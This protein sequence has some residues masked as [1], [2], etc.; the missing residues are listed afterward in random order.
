MDPR[1]LPELAAA[2]RPGDP[3]LTT[4]IA[5][6]VR[7]LRAANDPVDRTALYSLGHWLKARGIDA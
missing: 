2:R 3:S 5:D 4:L 6:R 7:R 1:P